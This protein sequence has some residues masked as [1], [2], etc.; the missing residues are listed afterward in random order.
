VFKILT[1]PFDPVLETFDEDLLNGF[2]LN[3]RVNR[4]RVVF[5]KTG[6]KA[7]WSV[8]LEYEPVLGALD[9]EGKDNVLDEAHRLLLD[10]LRAWRKE[11]SDKDGIPS[12]IVATNRELRE[13]VKATP[14][15]LEALKTIKGFGRKKMERYGSEIVAIVSTFF[16]ES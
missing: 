15:T 1:I 11:R 9:K 13:V 3:K 7:Y 16:D 6:E 8:F 12:Y 2:C 10:R 4:Y 5:F 14:R